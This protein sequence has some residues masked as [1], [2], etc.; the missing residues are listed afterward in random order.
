[1]SVKKCPICHTGKLLDRVDWN[2]IEKMEIDIPVFYSVCDDCGGEQADKWLADLNNEV[3]KQ[4][5]GREKCYENKPDEN[6]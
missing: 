5:L 3:Y 2:Y 1:M 4:L 6:S